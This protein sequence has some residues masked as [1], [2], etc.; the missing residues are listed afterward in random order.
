[1]RKGRLRERTIFHNVDII[2]TAEEGLAIG[3][4][5]DGRIIQVRGAVPGDKADVEVLEKRKGMLYT[6]PTGFSVFSEDRAEPFCAHFGIC[7]G[8]KWQHMTYDAQ[9]RYKEKRVRDA[10]ERI[11]GFDPDKIQPIVAAPSTQYYRNKLEF[12][13][14]EK[15]WL[16]IEE[17][18]Q[19]D[20]SLRRDGIG[21]HLPSSFD[22]VLDIQHC[23]LQQDPSN[24]IRLFIKKLC[25][26]R[27]WPFAN[28][29]VKT[30]FLRNVIVRNN[31]AGEFMVVLVVGQDEK[32][33]IQTIVSELSNQFPQIVSIYSCINLK[34][35]DSIHDLTLQHESGAET[36]IETL[37]HSR[38]HI[39]PKSFFQ[40]N[41]RQAAELY[42]LAKQLANLKPVDN[43]FDLYCGVG[44]LGIYMADSCRQVTGIEQIEEAILDARKNATLNNLHNVNFVAGQV[45]LMLDPLFIQ[46]YGKP[47]VVITDPPRAGMHP[48]VID[49][50]IEAAPD[51][52]VYVSCNP[53]TQARDM[54]ML[55]S[56]YD[57]VTAVPV[58]MFPQTHHIECVASL[59]RK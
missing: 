43:V 44:S 1:M 15:R 34:V 30:G 59:E 12:T 38:F 40:T 3:R 20:Q 9:L 28:L 2:D 13:A 46:Q 5:E 55:Q 36:L 56:A 27:N 23:H 58:D 14:S 4:C 52:I 19:L 32:E 45:E 7:G 33:W 42:A 57:L 25:M 11:G 18:Q 51:R 29:K 48:S 17:L 24:A 10:F 49:H 37:H 47:D 16:T 8:C 6:R 31:L 22:K 35:N 21:F 54:K 53:S 41:S 39:G 26:D 50:L